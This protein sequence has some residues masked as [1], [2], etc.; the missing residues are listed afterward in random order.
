MAS[1]SQSDVASP[2]SQ[3]RA[4]LARGDIALVDG[5]PV[6]AAMTRAQVKVIFPQ[7]AP[8]LRNGE[9]E[10]IFV[11]AEG[12]MDLAAN[13]SYTSLRRN[14]SGRVAGT[15]QPPHSTASP[16]P[17]SPMP[18]RQ[19]G[20]PDNSAEGNPLASCKTM[21]DRVHDH[22]ALPRFI[23]DIMD[24]PEFQRLRGLKQIGNT[25]YLYPGATHTRFEH[26]IGVAHLALTMARK[27]QLTQPELGIR[28][29]DILCVMAAGL[30][31]DLGHGPF[32]HLFEDVMKRA[33]RARGI[34]RKWRHEDMSTKLVRQIM[35]RANLSFYNLNEDD[36]EF[37]ILCIDGLQPDAPWPLNVGR[38]AEM[39][40]LLDIVANKRNGID[41]DKL[42][43][44]MRDSMCCYGRASVDCR[45]TR[46]T[47]CMRVINVN[48]QSQVCFEEKLAQSL[49][50]IFSLRAKLHK[51]AYQHRVPRVID[52][53]ITDALLAAEPFFKIRADDG[54]DRI[55]SDCADEPEAFTKLGDWILSAIETSS[56]D[57]LKP[58]QEI[59]HRLNSRRLYR[60]AGQATF[61]VPTDNTP[62][63]QLA[64][65]ISA[66]LP[67]DIRD[68]VRPSI[69]IEFIAI[70]YGSSDSR[71]APDDPISHVSFY[72]PKT[73]PNEA[74]RLPPSRQS[75]LFSPS[76]FAEKSML[77]VV[78]D[79]DY[80]DVVM[81][82]FQAWK[83]RYRTI[84]STPVPSFNSPAAGKR[85]RSGLSMERVD[86]RPSH[87][88]E[89][90]A[91]L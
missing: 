45:I 88:I 60:L 91:C 83:A 38:G 3:R 49:G 44:F 58:A 34:D 1:V 31:H 15:T 21:L 4:M 41:V 42:D 46:L 33:F 55:I 11:N 43:Y 52:L 36:V 85:T 25:H 26:S 77:V 63:D 69:A 66:Y 76:D 19:R 74:F 10:L 28:D 13:T 87:R 40:F 17:P 80:V 14:D 2:V 6:P 12:G 8:A 50:D 64:D 30:C 89:D 27:L 59:L 84:L 16:A 37:I 82:A 23:C 75:P 53:M 5:N 81:E 57:N 54:V 18:H 7:G 48:G 22:V 56:D 90:P 78:R 86:R 29:R 72:N 71:G 68:K 35:S 9:G 32:S 39:R 67:A 20:V 24:T 65:Q 70:N 61:L 51:Y 79:D 73:N 62:K 47:S